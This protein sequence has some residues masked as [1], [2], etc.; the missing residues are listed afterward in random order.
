M[1]DHP[2][3]HNNNSNNSNNTT[4]TKSK[5][6]KTKVNFFTGVF[7]DAAR[8]GFLGTRANIRETIRAQRAGESK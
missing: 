3:S 4:T 1:A 7:R 5:K 8:K 6:K 2:G